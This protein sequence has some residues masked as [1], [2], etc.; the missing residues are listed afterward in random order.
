M[1]RQALLAVDLVNLAGAGHSGGRAY[2]G[3]ADDRLVDQFAA[4]LSTETG[5]QVRRLKDAAVRLA[6]LAAA[7]RPAFTASDT[8]QAAAVL[9]QLLRQ[10][11]ARPYLTYDA[12]MPWH[13]HFHA[14]TN[15]ITDALGGEFAVALALIID[16]YSGKRLG[17]CQ[18]HVCDRVYVD[19][20]R[21]GSRRYCSEACSARAKTAAF[22]DRDRSNAQKPRH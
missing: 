14:D 17:V 21:N 16:T 3:A 18:A 19:L 2:P 4:E 20:T 8:S 9:N 11:D 12:D 13:L 22:R 7:F 10:Y 15:T 1:Q 5:H 6:E